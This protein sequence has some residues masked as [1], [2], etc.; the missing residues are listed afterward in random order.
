ML[1]SATR[2]SRGT[3][4]LMRVALFGGTFDPIHRAHIAIASVAAQAFSLDRVVFAPTGR[5]P[6]KAAP[7]EAPY[8]DRLK[9]TGLAITS[10]AA[11]PGGCEFIVS[12]LDAPPADGAPNY[13]V[14]ALAALARQLPDAE[15]WAIQGA[16]SFLSLRRWRAPDRLLELAEWIVVSRPG[17]PSTDEN[18]RALNLTPRQ[19]ARVHLIDTVH[20]DIS[21]TELRRRLHAG[22]SCAEWLYPLVSEYIQNRKLYR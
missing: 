3:M 19:R 7:P 6:L 1:N 17:T 18:L 8:L 11:I 14:D 20:Q 5:Q 22:D 13:T 21:S 9:M 15:L 2:V 16:D 12:G 4:M 10:A